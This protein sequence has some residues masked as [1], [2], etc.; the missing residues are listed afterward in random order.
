MNNCTA[1]T[2]HSAAGNM[3]S[4]PFFALAALLI[5]LFCAGTA[6]ASSDESYDRNREGVK[7]YGIIDSMPTAGFNGAW[8]VGG[9]EVEV[10]DRTRIKEKH[11]RAETGRYVEVEGFR[12]GNV[13]VAYEVEV[14]R[15]RE[16]RSG[17]RGEESKMYGTVE[18][19]PQ[20]GLD[21]TWRI[22]G[23]DITVDR[24]TRV[25]EEHSRIA[26]GTYVKVEGSYSGNNFIAYEIETKNDRRR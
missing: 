1:S 22:N 8:V 9:R 12:N 21:G 23:R 4:A 17:R 2:G 13:L 14:E 26:V 25:K 18:A 16:N 11:G 19:M 7:I 5:C 10:T 3:M 24:N 6:L 20:G 15:N